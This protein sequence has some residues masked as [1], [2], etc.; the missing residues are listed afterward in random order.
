MLFYGL[1]SLLSGSS[2]TPNVETVFSTTAA[3]PSIAGTIAGINAAAG[4]TVTAS[5]KAPSIYPMRPTLRQNF[6]VSWLKRSAI[7][8]FS[9]GFNF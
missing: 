3:V 7:F 9:K 8:I 1:S 4:G 2:L 6:G 5:A